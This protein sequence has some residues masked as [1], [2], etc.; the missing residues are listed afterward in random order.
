MSPLGRQV[1]PRS[2]CAL[3]QTL[4]ATRLGKAWFDK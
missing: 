2:T 3:L 1:V 4:I